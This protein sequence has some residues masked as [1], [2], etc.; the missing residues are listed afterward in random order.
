MHE[1]GVSGITKRWG[2]VTALRDVDLS[3]RAGE[4]LAILG[5][6]GCG[7]TTLLR[8][9]AGLEEPD[10]GDVVIAGNAVTHDPAW[11]R[12]IGFVFQNFALWPHL[13]V[14]RNVAMGLE[15]RKTGK[16]QLHD[17]VFAALRL[18]QLESLADR[19]PS[20]LSGGQQQRVALARAIVLKPAVL[21]LDEPLGALDKN[22]RQSMQV[23]LKTLQQTLGLTTIFVTHDQEEAMS[24]ADRVV[25][26]N[27]GMVEQL[28]TPE[29]IYNN[30]ASS[31]VARFVGETTFFE[32]RIEE[33]GIKAVLRTAHGMEI[34]L[35]GA[36]P[37]GEIQGV[38]FV[39]PE[40]ILLTKP[41]RCVSEPMPTGRIE[42]IMFFGSTRDFLIRFGETQI[43]VKA[44]GALDHFKTGDEVAL[45]FAAHLLP[46]E[47]PTV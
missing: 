13:N 34:P 40:W 28:D 30:P 37:S 44:A 42:R 20:Q 23:E 41:D 10:A 32:G 2:S 26:M 16:K 14:F 45:Q 15:L 18:V 8:I 4:F 29:V 24:L 33:R 43:R 31:F 17:S 7:K 35:R 1:I 9:I 5:P 27:Q 3:V 47:T 19:F 38:A 6:S 46:K 39:R 36:P 22:L 12:D 21:L 25:V 11:K